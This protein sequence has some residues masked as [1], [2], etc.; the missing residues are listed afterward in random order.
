MRN[1]VALGLMVLASLTQVAGC[2]CGGAT[3]VVA[4]KGFEDCQGDCG[5][6]VT[7]GRVQLVSTIH[8]GEHGLKLDAGTRLRWDLGDS[9]RFHER[10]VLG[11]TTNC[12]GTLR[13][14]VQID[15]ESPLVPVLL[16]RGAGDVTFVNAGGSLPDL[17][18][19]TSDG[20][21]RVPARFLIIESTSS[22]VIDNLQLV[23]TENY[24]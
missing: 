6:E 24:C 22:C 12:P 19:P 9:L 13:V 4:R 21:V 3:T 20:G 23:S 10:L 14:G 17:E 5:L 1:L 8:P 7:A 2:P 18:Q 15:A 16:S 11:L